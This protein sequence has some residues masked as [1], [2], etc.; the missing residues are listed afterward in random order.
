MYTI[1]DAARKL[2]SSKQSLAASTSHEATPSLIMSFFCQTTTPMTETIKQSPMTM[3]VNRLILTWTMMSML[4]VRPLPS[5]RKV[6]MK[7]LTVL[8]LDDDLNGIK[9]LSWWKAP[10]KLNRRRFLWKR[11]A[12]TLQLAG[13]PNTALSKNEKQ[14][15]KAATARVDNVNAVKPNAVPNQAH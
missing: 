5:T 3:E 8:L 7:L 11:M 4:Q 13:I 9:I 1:G 6:I 14:C 10:L 12:H 2:R 15:I